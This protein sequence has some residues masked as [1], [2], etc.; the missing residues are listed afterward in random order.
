MEQAT[1]RQPAAATSSPFPPG[2]RAPALV[3]A[4]RYA[5]DPLGFLTRFQRRHGDVF[6]VS[7][8]Y[9]GR[10]VY[11]AHPELVKDVFT[12]SP[13]QFHAGEANAT[14]LE[15]AL[16]PNSVLTLDDAPHM[17]QR[18]LLL[19]PF[20]GDRIRGYGELIRETTELEME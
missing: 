17:R 3:Q 18:K 20:H 14:V 6:T 7:F 16:G 11:V 15:P 4:L 10:I 5:R 8:P 1:I 2:P 19:P 9:F 12:G 13:A